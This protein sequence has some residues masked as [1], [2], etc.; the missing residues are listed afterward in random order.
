MTVTHEPGDASALAEVLRAAHSAGHVVD[1][2]GHGSRGPLG[3]RGATPDVR[4]STAAL[5]DLVAY[6]PADMTLTCQAGTPLAALDARLA[7]HGQWLPA[8]AYHRG[9]TVGGLV[10][11]GTRGALAAAHGATRDVL[12]GARFALADGRVA[13]ARGRVVKNVAGYDLPRL[14]CGSLGTLAVLV[15]ANLRVHPRPERQLTA[16]L[17][18]ADLPRAFD[19]AHVLRDAGLQPALLDVVRD[20]G[21]VALLLG[22]DGLARRVDGLFER[23]RAA[24]DRTDASL[25]PLDDADGL[26][27]RT[28][29]DDPRAWFPTDV[30][31]AHVPLLVELRARPSSLPALAAALLA[32]TP[33]AVL[34]ARPL[35][36]DLRLGVRCADDPAAV[37]TLDTWHAACAAVRADGPARLVLL[38]GPEPARVDPERVFGP[39]PSSHALAVDLR[40]ALD[41][42]RLL[43]RGRGVGGL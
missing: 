38:D 13:R 28:R 10:A 11:S 12:I 42:R 34:Q 26:A 32:V 39:P 9:G 4:L 35:L 31:D 18:C 41:P 21:G 14:L 24:C 7:E 33:D 27:A 5:D 36:G 40:A 2:R 23:A 37:R 1:V 3:A 19:A 15:E 16:R 43:G 6:D 29:A 20:D 17:A 25:Q 8:Q 30:G 22:L